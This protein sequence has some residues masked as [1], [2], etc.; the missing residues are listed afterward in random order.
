MIRLETPRLIIRNW[1]ERDR[2]LFFRINSDDEVM[3]FFPFRR[4]RTESDAFMDRIRD[5]N[6]ERG[7]GFA[8]LDL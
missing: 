5:A 6:E 7:D 8:A 2:D 4:S 3:R 1:E